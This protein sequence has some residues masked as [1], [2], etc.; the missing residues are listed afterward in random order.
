V[1]FVSEFDRGRI[2]LRQPVKEFG[3]D[4]QRIVQK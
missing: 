3:Q 4:G 2:E 1:R